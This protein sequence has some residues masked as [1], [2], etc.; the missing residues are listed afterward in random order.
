MDWYISCGGKQAIGPLP[1]SQVIQMLRAGTRVVGVRQV[2]EEE[3]HAPEIH[4]PFCRGPS[5]SASVCGAYAAVFVSA[6]G[7]PR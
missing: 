7:P 4:R 5:R 2:D 1:E 6:S 3:W